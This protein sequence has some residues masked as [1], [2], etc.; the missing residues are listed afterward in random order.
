MY[1]CMYVCMRIYI[2]SF[3]D[4]LRIF[5]PEPNLPNS[6]QTILSRDLPYSEDSKLFWRAIF[7]KAIFQH[8]TF[9]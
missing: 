3:P 5:E 7:Q 8:F 1:V 2:C 6:F 4:T 9:H